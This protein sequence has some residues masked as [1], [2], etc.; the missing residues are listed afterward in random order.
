M[1]L[2]LHPPSPRYI[3]SDGILLNAFSVLVCINFTQYAALPC[4]PF[5]FLC[6]ASG[7][8]HPCASSA[9]ISA[10]VQLKRRAQISRTCSSTDILRTSSVV[11]YFCLLHAFDQLHTH[12]LCSYATFTPE[13][14][15]INFHSVR[16]RVQFHAIFQI[17]LS[18]YYFSA[19]KTN[20]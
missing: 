2:P 3:R 6:S 13:M 12:S 19:F 7:A 18:F 15:R 14:I 17:S 1:K 16:P 5:D 11:A 9:A 20:S 8:R 4:L 10:T